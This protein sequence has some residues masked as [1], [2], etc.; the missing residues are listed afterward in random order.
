MENVIDPNWIDENGFLKPRIAMDSSGNGL[1]YTTMYYI[2]VFRSCN[3]LSKAEI[4]FVNARVDKCKL[5]PGLY[6]RTPGNTYGQEQFDDYLGLIVWCIVTDNRKLAREILWYGITH[7]GF[8]NTDGNLQGTDFL[9]RSVHIF[10]G[11][12]ILASFPSLK[13]LMWP[14]MWI[15]SRFLNAPLE[16]M[17]LDW[18]WF[19]GASLRGFKSTKLDGLTRQLATSLI[20]EMD[21]TNPA[22]IAARSIW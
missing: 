9:W 5:K 11:L 22:V 19:Y 15:C 1:L 21:I 4:D 18:L 7:A 12:G 10:I 16:K 6:A 17:Y 3:I 8:F 13:Y 2:I 20:Y 14:F